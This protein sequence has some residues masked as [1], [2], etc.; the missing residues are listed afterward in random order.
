MAT[1]TFKNIPDDLYEQ[2]KQAARAHHRSVNSEL[3]HCLEKTYK[4]TPIS[5]TELA[6]QA[7]ALRGRVSASQLSTEEI[8]NARNQGRE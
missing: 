3:I 2:L 4:P 7:L 6:E 1:V 5:A 8:N